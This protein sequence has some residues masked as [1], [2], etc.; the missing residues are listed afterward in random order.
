MINVFKNIEETK[1]ER[2]LRQFLQRLGIKK[3]RFSGGG[4]LNAYPYDAT[5]T[6]VVL[7]SGDANYAYRH[8]L[9]RAVRLVIRDF[10]KS[11]KFGKRKG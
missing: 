9:L 4:D 10:F 6:L 1:T 7:F 5:A 11:D 8:S 2:T 3:K